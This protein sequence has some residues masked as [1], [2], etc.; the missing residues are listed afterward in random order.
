MQEGRP[1][2]HLLDRKELPKI[3]N[4]NIN[5]FAN[6][7]KVS[8]LLG[9]SGHSF[10]VTTRKKSRDFL[11]ITVTESFYL[12]MYFTFL[13]FIVGLA[14][15]LKWRYKD[16]LVSGFVRNNLPAVGNPSNQITWETFEHIGSKE[17][18]PQQRGPLS[19][20]VD[21]PFVE[22]IDIYNDSLIIKP[23]TPWEKLKGQRYIGF[24]TP[25]PSPHAH[26]ALNISSA[27]PN[28]SHLPLGGEAS[29]QLGPS[30]VLAS[31]ARLY[32]PARGFVEFSPLA[33]TLPRLHPLHPLPP[34]GL[35]EV[36]SPLHR[37]H[38]MHDHA[39]RG[40]VSQASQVSAIPSDEFGV[41]IEGRS[42]NSLV[43]IPTFEDSA[44]LTESFNVGSYLLGTRPTSIV[45]ISDQGTLE[46]AADHSHG[47][48]GVSG[49]AHRKVGVFSLSPIKKWVY[50]FYG[51]LDEIPYKLGS[52][53][54]LPDNLAVIESAKLLIDNSRREE[55][56]TADKLVNETPNPFSELG[57]E[58]LLASPCLPSGGTGGTGCTTGGCG[59]PRPP[60]HGTPSSRVSSKP[61]SK[62]VSIAD[63][64][65]YHACEGYTRKPTDEGF[66]V[67][68][69]VDA[70]SGTNSRV[71][72]YPDRG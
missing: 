48:R 57:T 26:S 49:S 25:S 21:S 56:P 23:R 8:R 14:A 29:R 20:L 40:R 60:S 19:L 12:A 18:T 46:A 39:L 59:G 44:G 71:C 35:G 64:S 50:Q 67:E 22:R 13:V 63:T 51:Q 34:E 65:R 17:L 41:S 11:V 58:P 3:L 62:S 33:H 54:L 36:P 5:F 43:P 24:Y 15:S 31:S 61:R 30:S 6:L 38:G 69:K 45:R 32:V 2:P 37:M 4:M 42:S 47:L 52:T 66:K 1:C 28:L 16:Q 7:F 55:E 70:G 72:Q 53:K 27:T 68:Q 9:K 10:L